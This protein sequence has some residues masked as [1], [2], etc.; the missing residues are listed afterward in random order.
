MLAVLL[1]IVCACLVFLIRRSL[2]SVWIVVEATNSTPVFNIE[3]PELLE[4]KRI[5]VAEFEKVCTQGFTN[6][7]APL[8][9]FSYR[10]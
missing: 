7:L 10:F 4:A 3:Y 6:V 5:I 2:A 1:M 9:E 8:M